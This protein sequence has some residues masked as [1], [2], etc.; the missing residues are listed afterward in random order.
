MHAGDYERADAVL[1]SAADAS[2]GFG[3][4]GLHWLARIQ[5]AEL[6]LQTE[7]ATLDDVA[8]DAERAAAVFEELNDD[9][10]LARALHVASQVELQRGRHARQYELLERALVHA[11]RAGDE[12]RTASILVALALSMYL[13]P[14]PVPEAIE[15]TQAILERA[16]RDP[17]V[18]ALGASILSALEARRGQFDEARALSAKTRA[19][20]EDFGATVWLIGHAQHASEVELLAGDPLAAERELRAALLAVERIGDTSRRERLAL[21]LAEVLCVRGLYDEAKSAVATA[22][23][24]AVNAG[25]ERVISRIVRAKILAHDGNQAEAEMVARD[26]VELADGTDDLTL[27]ADAT[28]A[29]AETVGYRNG[30]EAAALATEALK[31]HETKGNV[32]RANRARAMVAAARPG[33][34]ARHRT[35]NPSR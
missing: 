15:R 14:T 5:R 2:A 16:R 11:E 6:A 17:T 34:D 27:R 35:L 22:S 33:R 32:V 3:N 9:G 1:A 4:R 24:A 10:G 28:L 8:R 20:L 21:K 23:S 13:G 12:R 26:A 7:R 19:M 18:Q 30:D 31:L 29:L 25:S